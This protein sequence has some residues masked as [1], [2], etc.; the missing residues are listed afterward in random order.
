M[1]GLGYPLVP[2]AV[3]DSGPLI[4]SEAAPARKAKPGEK[5]NAT[6]KTGADGTI[7]IDPADG[8]IADQLA[9]RSSS[10]T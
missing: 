7:G 3:D 4:I 8:Q 1:E 2:L 5:W 10:A 9:A 6:T